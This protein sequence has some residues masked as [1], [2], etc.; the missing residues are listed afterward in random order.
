M[1]YYAKIV[2]DSDGY[3]VEFPELEGCFSE[4]DTLEEAKLN[5]KEALDGW[6]ASNCDRKLNIP[7]PVLRAKRTKFRSFY[8]IQV[9]EQIAF[10]IYL[11]RSRKEKKFSQKKIADL[12]GVTQQAY[13]KLETPGKANPRLSTIAKLKQILNIESY[14]I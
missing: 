11:R 8:P 10:S 2:K 5:A 13:A 7:E 6:L 14:T 3:F 4:G 9:D 12:I 1:V